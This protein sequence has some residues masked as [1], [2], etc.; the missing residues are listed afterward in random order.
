M[1][2]VENLL[3]TMSEECAEIQQAISKSLRFGFNNYN[4][5]TPN[6]T[7]VDDIMVEFY[8]LCAVFELLQDNK[9]LPILSDN[10][11]LTIKN[12]KKEKI[13]QYQKLSTDIG[14]IQGE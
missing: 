1:N 2:K 6:K 8:Q 7:N 4:P 3:T 11:I 5:Q 12:S 13:V 9:V 14:T 10:I